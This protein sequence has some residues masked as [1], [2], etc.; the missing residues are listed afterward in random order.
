MEAQALNTKKIAPFPKG[1]A[2][3]FR[4]NLN[5]KSKLI[6]LNTRYR[7]TGEVRYLPPV[8]KEWKNTIYSYYKHNMQSL[9]VDNLNA[10]KIIRYYFGLVFKDDSF[11]DSRTVILNK[12]RLF[13]RRIYVSNL[14]TKHTNSKAIIT[15]YTMNAEKKFLLIKCLNLSEIL[16]EKILSY[17]RKKLN[18][19]INIFRGNDLLHLDSNS[20]DLEDKK[21]LGRKLGLRLKYK[22]LSESLK[23]SN[24]YLKLYLSRAMKFSYYNKLNLLRKYQ[25]SYNLNEYKFDNNIY[26]S[27]LSN[28]LSKI[29]KKKI[30]FNIIN[31][32]SLALD[33]D[34]LTEYLSLRIRS[35]DFSVRDILDNYLKQ[36]ILP[37]VRKEGIKDNNEVL[38]ANKYKNL[39]L[40]SIFN[41]DTNGTCSLN[42]LLKEN[43]CTNILGAKSKKIKRNYINIINKN[44]TNISNII[45]NSIKYKSIGGIR[46][47]VRG[48][49]SIHSTADRSLTSFGWKGSLKNQDS[50][51]KNLPTVTYRGSQKSSIMSS[52]FQ[53]KRNLGVFAVKG[54]I[55]GK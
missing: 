54:W 12:K 55:S 52:M 47:E 13:L 8:S 20:M 33:T 18:E 42:K 44:Y 31:L 21:K 17:W 50:S 26:L 24:L 35:Q 5:N 40:I 25:L 43:Y 15:L 46:F 2:N 49:L 38:L 34:I 39:S 14:E 7:Y 16:S 37:E 51:Y 36:V 45:F 9:P 1:R 19:R 41:K 3:I 32:K 23:W 48:R 22:Y 4:F 6:P 28:I 10:N 29:F 53:A 30:E 27:K 11:I